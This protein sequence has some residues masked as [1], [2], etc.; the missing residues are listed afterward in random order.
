MVIARFIKFL[1]VGLGGSFS[2][3][4]EVGNISRIRIFDSNTDRKEENYRKTGVETV[5]YIKVKGVTEGL[6]AMSQVDALLV[7]VTLS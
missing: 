6:R 5:G 1:R 7:Y 4:R 2:A 3:F